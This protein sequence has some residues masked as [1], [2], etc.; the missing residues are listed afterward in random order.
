VAVGAVSQQEQDGQLWVIGYASRCLDRA[1]WTYCRTQKEL[2]GVIFSLSKFRQFLL[3]RQFVLRIDHDVLTYLL[4][5][6][7]S[8]GQRF[9]WL[10]LLE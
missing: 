9:R 6:S 1:L 2:Y 3:A 8:A 7:E 4:R 10:D 5:T